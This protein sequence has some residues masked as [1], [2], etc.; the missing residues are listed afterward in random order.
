MYS[1]N[2]PEGSVC[3][4]GRSSSGKVARKNM[5]IL[6]RKQRKIGVV[7]MDEWKPLFG[8][9]LNDVNVSVGQIFE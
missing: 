9:S 2:V 3:G 8:V 1:F 6:K 5:E 4:A 7:K